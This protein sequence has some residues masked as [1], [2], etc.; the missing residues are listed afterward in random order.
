VLKKIIHRGLEIEY[1]VL[2]YSFLSKVIIRRGEEPLLWT[3]M[4]TNGW[5]APS[6]AGSSCGMPE[7]KRGIA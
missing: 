6:A 7:N 3:I 2:L 1:F 5:Y 4:P